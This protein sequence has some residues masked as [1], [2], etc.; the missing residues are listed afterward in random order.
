MSDF[1][2]PADLELRILIA[3]AEA[4]LTDLQ[5]HIDTVRK[6]MASI[7][8]GFKCQIERINRISTWSGPK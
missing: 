4:L 7:R 1:E 2:T 3:D 5:D 6:E 8:E